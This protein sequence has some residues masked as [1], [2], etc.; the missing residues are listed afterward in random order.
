MACPVVLLNL[1]FSQETH[2]CSGRETHSSLNGTLPGS[3][4]AALSHF[5]TF[6]TVGGAV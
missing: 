3:H 5:L 2:G 1:S 4:T 6:E